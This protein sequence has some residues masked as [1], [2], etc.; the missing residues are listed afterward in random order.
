MT[1]IG[2][3]TEWINLIDPLIPDIMELI[4]S[5][6]KELTPIEANALEDPITEKLCRYLR[7]NRDAS[8]LPFRIDIQLVELDSAFEDDQGRM[9]IVFSPMIAR[10]N[11]YFCLECKRLNVVT[12]GN[13]RSYSREYVING[14]MRYVTG[15]YSSAMKHGGMLGY[16]LNG[17]VAKAIV[18]VTGA[19]QTNYVALGMA[20]PPTI[21]ASSIRPKDSRVKETI[22]TRKHDT[23]AFQMHHMFVSAI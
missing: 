2:S 9:D 14:M 3:P 11:I 13:L 22:H 7:Q 4:L 19:I 10:E 18:N 1:L 17:N 23:N 6:W 15:K 12:N 8:D 5:S 20:R 16:V 21:A